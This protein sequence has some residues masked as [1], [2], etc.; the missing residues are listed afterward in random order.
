MP[1]QFDE[2]IAL[3]AQ[4]D[5]LALLQGIRRGIEKES[6]RIDPRGRLATT[7]HPQAFGSALTHANITTDFSE[8]LLELITGVHQSID[9]TLE[10]LDNVH[11]FVYSTLGSELLWGTSMPCILGAHEDIPLARYGSSNVATMKTVYRRGLGHRYGRRM[12]TIA[13]IHYNFSLSDTLWP[14]LQAADHNRQSSQRYITDAYFNLIRNF[15]RCVWLLV[16]LFGASP[17]LCRSFLGEQPHQLDSLDEATLYKPY[18][19]SLRMGDLGYQSNAQ[20]SLNICYNCIENYIQT[21]GEAIVLPHADYQKIGLKKDGEYQQL[22]TALLQIENEFYSPIRPKRVASS[23]ETPLGVLRERG[24]EYIEVRCL[25]VNPYLPMGIDA[26]QMRFLDCFL[27]YCLFDQ[28]PLCDDADRDRIASNLNLVVNE[29]RQ[30]GLMLQRRHG[31]AGLREWGEELL[32]GVN[33]IAQLLDRAHGG[34]H[35]QQSCAQ[36]LAKLRDPALTPSARVLADLSA[37]QQTFVDFALGHSASHAEGFHAQPLPDSLR[38]YF[39]QAADASFAA[40]HRIEAADTL[41][42]DDYLRDY[43]QQYEALRLTSA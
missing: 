19:T 15:R 6:L 43:F 30:P 23:G 39:E 12:Q 21:L 35:Y 27:L 37:G 2:R 5:N 1:K 10:E 9:G 38:Q 36:Q 28:S 24:V 25:D 34:E 20:Q 31:P 8:A 13:G 11:R 14:V 33:Q 40:Q 42:F 16:Y 3:F 41:S 29:G 17:A 7:P 18:G 26:E 22:S 4:P 32:E